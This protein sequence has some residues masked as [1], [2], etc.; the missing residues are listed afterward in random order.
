MSLLG[1]ASRPGDFQKRVPRNLRT[2]FRLKN[3]AID[4]AIN[5]TY[6]DEG[7]NNLSITNASNT[8]TRG[9]GGFSPFSAPFGD[10][11]MQLACTGGEALR[12][13]IAATAALTTGT[14][15]DYTFECFLMRVHYNTFNTISSISTAG[16]VTGRLT[17]SGVSIYSGAAAHTAMKPGKWVHFVLNRKAGVLS[18]YVG[19]V[20]LKQNTG[21]AGNMGFAATN[22]YL[23]DY[24]SNNGQDWCGYM[25]NLRIVIGSAVYDGSPTIEVPTSAL[26]VV[27]NTKFLGFCGPAMLDY[28]G[29]GNTIVYGATPPRMV[30]IGPF[31]TSDL[32]A[33]VAATHGGSF[34]SGGSAYLTAPAHA[35]HA[36]GTGDFTI[37]FWTYLH[38]QSN[39]GVL[40]GAW[41]GTA[42]TSAWLVSQGSTATN[43]GVRVVLSN[44][45]SLTAIESTTGAQ[46]RPYSWVHVAIC[47][48]GGTLYMF[49]NGIQVYSAANT[50]NIT[51]TTA[52]LGIMALPSGGNPSNGYIA[53]L[54]VSNTARYTA[55]FSPP[56]A[57]VTSDANTTLL[58]N[59]SNPAIWD[60]S[61]KSGIWLA[62]NTSI[63]ADATAPGTDPY[64]IALDGTGDYIQV[65]NSSANWCFGGD[66]EMTMEFW[67][68]FNNAAG[69]N[70]FLFD[71]G[72][73]ALQ[74]N[75]SNKLVWTITTAQTVRATSVSNFSTTGK[76][77]HVAIVRVAGIIRMFI[78]GNLEVTANE[79]G[80]NLSDSTTN[81]AVT[82]IGSKIDNTLGL[83]G[84]IKGF[85]VVRYPKYM[86]AFTPAGD[87]S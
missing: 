28:S 44:G 86:S 34:Y 19:G 51:S 70:F 71:T 2:I 42:G 5:D 43:G 85:N 68:N 45:S 38:S 53:N 36:F 13:Y 40:A 33:Y 37:E 16:A 69:T 32:D 23:G 78:D 79:S 64:A 57:P 18:L 21:D 50:I 59:F 31:G 82:L 61:R 76:W 30:P 75:T 9:Q 72:R 55:A 24:N 81:M 46:L 10:W 14:T 4:Q 8:V 66:G 60:D 27:P 80:D 41:T 22:A 67:V 54:K 47:R 6:I 25:S 49:L 63:V 77:Y 17:N 29:N 20:L 11:A 15:A 56:T 87:L 3:K 58:L 84:K 26:T 62:G 48:S 74:R 35:S 12:P 83:N 65:L 73:Y 1:D 7:P 39:N 52:P